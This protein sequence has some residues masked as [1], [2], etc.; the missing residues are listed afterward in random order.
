MEER[1]IVELFFARSFAFN[2]GHGLDA[3]LYPGAHISS[4]L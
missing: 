3:L 4:L 2:R 1:T